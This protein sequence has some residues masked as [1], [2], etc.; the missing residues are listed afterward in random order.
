MLLISR[1]SHAYKI[2]M[3]LLITGEFPFRS[4][5]LLGNERMMKETAVRMTQV[6]VIHIKD[7]EKMRSPEPSWRSK[8]T[9]LF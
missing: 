4:L 6:H 7:R 5:G 9:R 3:L 8:R 1:G 2:I